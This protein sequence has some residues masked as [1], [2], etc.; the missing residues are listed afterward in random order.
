MKSINLSRTKRKIIGNAENRTRGCW[1]RSR[2]ATSVPRSPLGC[3][4]L[5]V[6]MSLVF[7]T[8]AWEPCKRQ[9]WDSCCPFQLGS[10]EDPI[11]CRDL[12]VQPELESL[13]D[14]GHRDTPDFEP[15]TPGISNPATATRLREATDFLGS[16]S[17]KWT[18]V[19]LSRTRSL[20]LQ[21]T[22]P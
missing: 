2:Y 6:L 11:R 19:G 18:M 20:I 3:S 1:M 10:R 16:E 17:F 22:N 21:F 4:T 8:C 9:W 5:L 14:S 15:E 7:I 12:R 13:P